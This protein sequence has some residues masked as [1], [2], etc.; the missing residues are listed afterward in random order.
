MAEEKK[1]PVSNT[2]EARQ[3]QLEKIRQQQIKLAEKAGLLSKDA[4]KRLIKAKG[5]K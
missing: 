5:N 3:K 1:A 4:A 2:A